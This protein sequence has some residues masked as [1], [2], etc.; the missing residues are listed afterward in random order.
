MPKHKFFIY[1]QNINDTIFSNISDLKIYKCKKNGFLVF[2]FL[3]TTSFR[4]N[5][6][7]RFP[8]IF[9]SLYTRENQFKKEKT[10]L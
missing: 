5:R 1:I 2:F 3:K 4:G 10:F 8:I 9:L 6:H 7:I